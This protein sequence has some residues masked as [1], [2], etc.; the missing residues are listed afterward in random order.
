MSI[1]HPSFELGH[2]KFKKTKSGMHLFAPTSS[3]LTQ[4]CIIHNFSDYKYIC[5]YDLSRP[6]GGRDFPMS[7]RMVL[8][9]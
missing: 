1:P 8:S 5:C 6:T 2:F 9:K 4:K 3:L 7:T